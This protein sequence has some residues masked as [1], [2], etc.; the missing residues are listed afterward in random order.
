MATLENFRSYL[1]NP[2]DDDQELQVYLDA[3]KQSA[4]DAGVPEHKGNPKYDLFLYALASY[5][6]DNRGFSFSGSY[7][8]TAETN[9]RRMINS[10]VLEL[11]HSA[12]NEETS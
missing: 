8:A 4:S 10:M 9:A 3:A 7:Q 1:R 11:R 2:P 12:I 5:Y 6:Y